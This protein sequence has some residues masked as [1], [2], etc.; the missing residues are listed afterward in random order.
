M[1]QREFPFMQGKELFK[2]RFI[3]QYFKICLPFVHYHW[4]CSFCKHLYSICW[5]I[6]V[7]QNNGFHYNILYVDIKYSGHI[8]PHDLFLSSQ[9]LFPSS[10]LPPFSSFLFC[11]LGV[12]SV[13][14]C[15]WYTCTCVLRCVHMCEH[16]ME[17]DVGFL[18]S[19]VLSLHVDLVIVWLDRQASKH[20]V[21]CFCPLPGPGVRC[22][23]QHPADLGLWLWT[24]VL[25][26]VL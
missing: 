22:M 24:V 20:W 16:S 13:C 7:V 14:V 15:V 5:Y 18:L 10:S 8:F 25:R 6:F 19:S 17:K 1:T 9:S 2:I 21:F 12:A 23:G 11:F 26:P 3:A 4:N